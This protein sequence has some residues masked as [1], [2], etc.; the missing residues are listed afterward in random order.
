[1]TVTRL[2]QPADAEALSA[3]LAEAFAGY[4]EWAP[5]G[6]APPVL[7][8]AVVSGLAGALARPDVW[9]LVALDAEE[10]IGHVAVSLFTMENPEP[11]P[12]GTINLWQLFVRPE[13][14]GQGVATGL[15]DAAVGEAQRRG[16][17]RMRLWTPE[18]AARARRFYEREGWVRT[19]DIHVDSPFGL[20]VVE[21][22]R[23]LD[24]PN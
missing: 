13:C 11:P 10:I 1:M 7:S 2:A 20:P 17:N 18:G 3:V 22:A 5:S 15:M 4:R 19:G 12:P 8:A 14:H 23:G 9:C 21:Y 24:S 16:F 6:W